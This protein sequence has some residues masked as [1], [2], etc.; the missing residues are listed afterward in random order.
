MTPT[1]TRLALLANGYSPL[2]NRDKRTF[3]K[4]W[5]TLEI[6]PSVIREWETGRHRRDVATGVRQ[7]RGLVMID[8]DID[9]EQAVAEFFD[10]AVEQVPQIEF[11]PVRMGGGAKEGWFFRLADGE[12]PFRYCGSTGHVRPGEDPENDSLPIHRVEVWGGAEARQ[13]GAYGPHT[14][15]DAG[16]VERVYRWREDTGGLLET[17]FEKL[18]VIT[19]AEIEKLCALAGGLL[20]AKGW[21]RSLRVKAGR[22]NGEIAYDLTDAMVFDCND[23]ETRKLQQLR[24]YIRSSASPRCSASW[25]EGPAAQNRTR[26]L[27]SLT[28]DGVI[29]ILDTASYD[30]H[31]PAAAKVETT[32]ERMDRLA[33]ALEDKGHKLEVPEDAPDSFKTAV[34]DLH[35]N[36]VFNP[37]RQRNCLPIYDREDASATL[38]NLRL[39]YAPH[40]VETEPG[41]RGGRPKK[42]NPVDVW[43]NSPERITGNIDYRFAP[44]RPRGLFEDHGRRFINSYTPIEHKQPDPEIMDLWVEFLRHLLPHDEEREWFMDWLAYKLQNLAIPGV[45]VLMETPTFGT[46]R[47]TLTDIITAAVGARH[48]ATITAT[49]LLGG[50]SQSQYNDW[51]VGRLFI[52][53]E[54]VLQD[55]EDSSAM[56]WKRKKSYERMK[57]FLDPRPREVQ[58][59]RKGLPN[60]TDVAAASYL[61]AT[62]HQGALPVETHDRRFVVLRNTETRLLDAPDEL[63]RRLFEQKE[64]GYFR[65]AMGAAVWHWAQ[66]RDVSAFD[67]YFAP[68]WGGKAE[69]S[70]ANRDELDDLIRDVLTQWP[71]DWADRSTFGQVV[72]RKAEA[73]GLDDAYR[74]IRRRATDALQAEWK[75]TPRGTMMNFVGSARIVCFRTKEEHDRVAGLSLVQRSEELEEQR[76][77][78]VAPTP[79]LLAARLGLTVHEGG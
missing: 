77:G 10:I 17:P 27:L 1:Q 11:A 53:I 2:A 60:Y 4:G 26:C 36:Y 52:F 44:G 67:P 56:G 59:N 8:V 31:Q 12:K 71:H 78:N 22:H 70:T 38:T 16:E 50:Q 55:G 48:T 13:F 19:L 41:P 39:A 33:K 15:N 65:E 63:A 68:D 18:P 61:M 72:R 45:A 75:A 74:S 49:Q 24:D 23:G 66:E 35:E 3:M 30:R 25:L 76:K 42:I 46:G 40:A 14:V 37:S 47:G 21:P 51:L 28:H 54:E 69:M 6:T 32:P 64:G 34:V 9:D 29:S 43:V 57:E 20:T 79:Q 58:I 73:E 7:E 5:P 62:N